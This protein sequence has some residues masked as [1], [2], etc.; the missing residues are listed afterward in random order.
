MSSIGGK[1]KKLSALVIEEI[2]RMV[3]SGS[4]KEGDRLPN[5]YD[6]AE[7]LGVSRPSLREA[8][9]ELT[10]AGVL[11]QRPGAGTTLKT[12]NTDLWFG[13]SFAPVLADKKATLEL[14][15]ARK[16][17]EP[18]AVRLA[19]GRITD[20]GLDCVERSIRKMEDDFAR[21]NV[22]EY[23]KEDL[24]FHYLIARAAGNRYIQQMLVNLRLLME[25]FM[26]ESFD[27]IG[28]L[29]SNSLDHHRKIGVELK[30]RDSAGSVVAL[31][32]HLGDIE[33]ALRQYYAEHEPEGR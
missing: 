3:E 23:L 24:N 14:I 33:S 7:Q 10:S 32:N 30:R 21:G 20:E 22:D 9:H 29:V 6:L 27:L 17:I 18:I 4:L 26:K 15:E 28:G 12:G 1:K 25:E 2:R 16:E 8:L 13:M 11:E 19:A 5:Q 31:K